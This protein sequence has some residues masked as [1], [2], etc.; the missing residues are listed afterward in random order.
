M[1][2]EKKLIRQR[3]RDECFKRDK[4]T[5][6]MCGLK[7]SPEKALDDL[8]A[9]HIH[10]REDMVGGGYV[11][12]NGITLCKAPNGCH[13]KAEQFYSTGTAFPGYSPNELYAKIGSS[14]EQAI[15]AC[16]RLVLR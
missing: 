3:F 9:H 2:N 4:Y 7:S 8:D 11:K 5:C 15:K 10:P 14:Y 13:E 12:D 1:G 6:V 16:Q